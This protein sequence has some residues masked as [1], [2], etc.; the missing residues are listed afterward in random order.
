MNRR[1]AVKLLGDH[2][3]HDPRAVRRFQREARTA[4]RLSGH[5]NI[6][7]IFDVGQT[8]QGDGEACRPFP[9]ALP[10]GIAGTGSPADRS[11][12][13]SI[14]RPNSD[15][16]LA[17]QHKLFLFGPREKP[18]LCEL[19]IRLNDMTE[20]SGEYV[21]LTGITAGNR[22]MSHAPNT[23]TIRS[24]TCPLRRRAPASSRC[25]ASP[26]T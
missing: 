26:P 25:C 18:S 19:V 21:M 11:V 10:R 14:Q 7:T 23:P 17:R 9:L 22:V 20:A 8:A 4:A 6:V 3:A 12:R 16:P 15:G 24:R 1:V 2:F 5:P 13:R